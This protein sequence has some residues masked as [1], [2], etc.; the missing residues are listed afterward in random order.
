M[1]YCRERLSGFRFQRYA[2]TKNCRV[3]R[4]IRRNFALNDLFKRHILPL[5]LTQQFMGPGQRFYAAIEPGH[6]VRQ[7]DPSFR[8][9]GDDSA[10]GSEHVLHT[11]VELSIQC[12]L[13]FVCAFARG[14]IDVNAYGPLR[15]AVARVRHEHPR[16]DPAN[17][18]S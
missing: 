9:L 13:L 7:R 11:M 1:K 8:C 5:V 18:V 15:P 4:C 3:A 14:D 2:R 17:L 16:L 10:D 12:A 6:K